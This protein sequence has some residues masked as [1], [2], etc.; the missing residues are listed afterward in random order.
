M[1]MLTTLM[2]CQGATTKPK[3]STRKCG[4]RTTKGLTG[5]QEATTL[6]ELP[7]ETSTTVVTGR[8]PRTSERMLPSTWLFAFTWN[9][10]NSR[11]V[12]SWGI[13]EHLGIMI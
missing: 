13:R 1:P 3:M 7:T 12:H 5:A 2:A 4:C 6:T 8:R 11:V 9:K 10:S